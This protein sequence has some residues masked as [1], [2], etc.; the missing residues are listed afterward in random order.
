MST[1]DHA[2]PADALDSWISD[3]SDGARSMRRLRQ[4]LGAEANLVAGPC[5]ACQRSATADSS[6]AGHWVADPAD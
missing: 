4:R 2:L 1:T 3:L 6:H 5:A